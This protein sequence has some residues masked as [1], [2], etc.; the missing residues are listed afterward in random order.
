MIAEHVKVQLQVVKNEKVFRGVRDDQLRFGRHLREQSV[1]EG[2]PF[3]VRYINV[4]R[5]DD[6]SACPE[7]VGKVAHPF[8]A[9]NLKQHFPIGAHSG[10]KESV[11]NDNLSFDQSLTCNDF[12]SKLQL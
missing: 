2:V 4:A 10:W 1:P 3:L 8:G 9:G 12:R 5:V 11:G 6:A 7:R